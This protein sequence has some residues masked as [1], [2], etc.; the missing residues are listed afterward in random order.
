M[1]QRAPRDQ[2]QTIG[3]RSFTLT[4]TRWRCAA[5]QKGGPL[6]VCILCVTQFTLGTRPISDDAGNISKE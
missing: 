4:D 6:D 5:V 2:S 3:E 1:G